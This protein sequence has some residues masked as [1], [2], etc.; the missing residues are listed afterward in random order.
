[1]KLSIRC[2]ILVTVMIILS[3]ILYQIGMKVVIPYLLE[4]NDGLVIT[5]GLI[6]GLMIVLTIWIGVGEFLMK[7]LNCGEIIDKFIDRSEK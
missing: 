2:S 1:M 5:G 6:L 7:I 4:S 3:V